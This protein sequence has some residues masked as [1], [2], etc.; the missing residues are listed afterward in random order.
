MLAVQYVP[1]S[2]RVWTGERVPRASDGAL[3]SVP[4]SVENVWSDGELSLYNLFRVEL[5]VVPD[6]K[7]TIGEPWYERTNAHVR[8]LFNVEDIPPP[9]DEELDAIAYQNAINAAVRISAAQLVLDSTISPEQRAELIVIYPPWK[10]DEA[11]K[12]GDLR[13]YSGALYRCVQAHTTQADW[14]PPAVPA[15]WTEAVPSGVIAAWRQPLGSFDAYPAGAI[16][17]H[18]AQTW[19][20]SRDANVWEPGT[21]DAG[22]WVYSV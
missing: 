2:Y 8:Q 19:C 22:W 15:L 10:A 18:N 3:V 20:S 13:R 1:G 11:V 21:F 7:Q 16:V 14:T 12:I 9:S 5:F 17:T 6:G 4:L